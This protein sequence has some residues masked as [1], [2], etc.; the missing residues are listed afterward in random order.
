MFDLTTLLTSIPSLLNAIDSRISESRGIERSLLLELETNIGIIQPFITDEI[1]IDKVI[2]QLDITSM[3]TAI[4]TGYK[5]NSIN[6]GTVAPDIVGCNRQLMRYVGWST[7]KLFLSIYEKIKVLKK[8]VEIAPENQNI[9]KQVR[10]NNILL[11]MA[12]LVKH[13]EAD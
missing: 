10:L 9:R 5:F 4:G 13:I 7:E 8:V 2:Q 3:Q 12:L 6:R 1:N 11:L